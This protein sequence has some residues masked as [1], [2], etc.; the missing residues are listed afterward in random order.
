[1]PVQA[2]QER[3]MSQNKSKCTVSE[4]RGVGGGLRPRSGITIL[5]TPPYM[6]IFRFLKSIFTR[7]HKHNYVYET[8]YSSN[9]N[10]GVIVFKCYGCGHLYACK[11]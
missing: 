3:T 7:K 6:P 5:T 10:G 8:M 11:G 1:M 9:I 4:A 2:K